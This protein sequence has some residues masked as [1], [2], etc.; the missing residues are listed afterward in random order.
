MASG[1]GQL[2]VCVHSKQERWG[3]VSLRSQEA[4]KRFGTVSVCSRSSWENK[5]KR[6]KAKVTQMCEPEHLMNHPQC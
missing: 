3:R 6:E 1:G 5:K 4:V 2:R